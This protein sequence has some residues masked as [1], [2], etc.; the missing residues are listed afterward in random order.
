MN[1]KYA[2][3]YMLFG[4]GNNKQLE[5]FSIDFGILL[6]DLYQISNID[7]IIFTILLLFL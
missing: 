5:I 7:I 3:F 2:W 1:L 6:I 4:K